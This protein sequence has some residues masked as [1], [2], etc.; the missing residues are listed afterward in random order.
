MRS[1]PLYDRRF[2][3]DACGVGFIAARDLGASYRLTRLA[4]ECLI[5]LE[6]RGAKAAD[7]TG[8]GAGILTQ[9]PYRLLARELSVR[10]LSVPEPGRLGVMGVFFHRERAEAD[11]QLVAKAIDGEGLRYLGFRPVPNH[12]AVL[13][14]RAKESLPRIEQVLIEA[15]DEMSEDEFERRLFLARKVAERGLQPG[16]TIISSSSRTVV[17]KGLLAPSNLA[18]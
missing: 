17:Y 15:P 9:V 5:R 8:D 16:T 11:R 12:P 14:R 18:D 3:H 2:E 7:G 6:H 13:S 10:N 1:A 4:V